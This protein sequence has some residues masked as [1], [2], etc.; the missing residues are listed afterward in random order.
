MEIVLGN[1]ALAV[2][3][4][5]GTVQWI[6]GFFKKSPTWIWRL[7]LPLFAIGWGFLMGKMWVDRALYAGL[8]IALSEAGYAA[9]VQ[10]LPQV[11]A[12]LL[13]KLKR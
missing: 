12:S 4:T 3:A 6:K 2:I 7:L 9:I 8:I 5:V 1:V 13:E 11:A 10:G